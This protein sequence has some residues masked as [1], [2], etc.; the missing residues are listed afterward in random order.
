MAR[1]LEDSKWPLLIAWGVGFLG[2]GQ[3][4]FKPLG[5]REWI[6]N[7]PQGGISVLSLSSSMKENWHTKASGNIPMPDE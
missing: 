2:A 4:P 3:L 7:S 1:G 5:E 6:R